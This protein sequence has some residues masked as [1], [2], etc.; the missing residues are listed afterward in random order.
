MSRGA[1][2]TGSLSPARPDVALDAGA[3]L[4]AL[5]SGVVI[6]ARDWTVLF[7]NP[8]AGSLLGIPGDGI[9][10]KL[11]WDVLPDLARSPHADLLRGAMADGAPRT[12]RLEHAVADRRLMVEA[13]ATRSHGGIGLE[14]TTPTASPPPRRDSDPDLANDDSAALR[15]LARE[16][17]A[18][19]DTATMLDALAAAAEA[20][21]AAHG[22]AVVQLRG[23]QGEFVAATPGFGAPV[24]SR[25]ALLDSLT[26]R[27]VE[28]RAAVNEPDYLGTYG[29]HVIVGARI[30]PVLMVPLIA[31]ERILGV[32]CCR[33]DP[34][35]PSFARR[36]ER[37]L[38]VIADYASL[39]LWKSQLLEEA[40]SAGRAKGNFL[41]TMSHELRT[42]LAALSG[43]GELLADEILGRL[44]HDQLD[45]VERMRSVTHHLSVMIEEILTFSR[46]EVGREAVR[47][48]HFAARDVVRATVA[49]VEPVAQQK[50][51]RL[52][53]SLPDHPLSLVSDVD[54]VRQI[55]VNLSGNAVK[56]TESGR[57]SIVVR[58]DEGEGVVRFAVQ[59]SGIGIAPTDIP[60]LF[61]PFAQLDSG[62]TRRHN[63][64]G[65]GLYISHRLAKLL[66]GR[67]EVRS[68]PGEGSVFTLLVPATH[69]AKPAAHPTH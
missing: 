41:A 21:C 6:V 29:P 40:E 36:E 43:Y 30:G 65:L 39:V 23:E 26:Q 10:G 37:Q 62:L 59:D 53:T 50:G 25:F 11:L 18:T 28:S 7:V 67:I 56:F 34:G 52:D 1:P 45:V 27:V 32:L 33:R 14:L 58:R 64:T 38:R 44:S 4:A 47:L 22:A 20:R 35:T 31:S 24:G 48:T 8:A 54:K 42:P 5:R 68:T 60:R 61:H 16:L 51:I 13:I 69:V 63:G 46:I 15:H 49:V 66:G 55:L 3:V 19:P 57:V 9:A 17:A 12:F 2:A